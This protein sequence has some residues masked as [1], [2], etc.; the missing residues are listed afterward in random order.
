M[1][2]EL[3]FLEKYGE[4]NWYL[5]NKN[6]LI[7]NWLKKSQGNSVSKKVLDFG[8]GAGH[9]AKLMQVEGF[10]VVATD[11]DAT[12][13]KLTGKKG[14]TIAKFEELER[15]S[16]DAIIAADVFEHVAD[17]TILMK[18]LGSLLK[19]A[20]VL[21]TTVPAM[22]SL[23]G[24]RDNRLGHFRRYEKMELNNKLASSGFEVVFTRFW[25]SFFC[26]MVYL[27]R[28]FM[29]DKDVHEFA[30]LP[31]SINCLLGKTLLLEQYLSFFPFGVTLFC[32]AKTN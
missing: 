7:V 29:K 1:K 26:P 21:I 3:E 15:N 2:N 13:R 25:N 22:K 11:I 30:M 31:N 20:G 18:K 6:L 32:V 8:C 16:F 28:K 23:W 19:K 4:D 24:I 12:A 27:Q 10:E 14:I 5:H 9:L 17:D